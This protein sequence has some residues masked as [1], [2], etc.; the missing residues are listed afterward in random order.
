MTTNTMIRVTYP[1]GMNIHMGEESLILAVKAAGVT[2][3]LAQR[4]YAADIRG[5][6]ISRDTVVYDLPAG[7]VIFRR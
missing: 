1:N 7:S 2:E 6:L 5:D 4:G 3:E